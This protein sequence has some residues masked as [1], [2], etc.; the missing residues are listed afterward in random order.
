MLAGGWPLQEALTYAS[1]SQ[2][3]GGIREAERGTGGSTR[4]L[5]M[6]VGTAVVTS[7]HARGRARPGQTQGWEGRQG[8][9]LSLQ[10]GEAAKSRREAGRGGDTA[11]ISPAHVLT[12]APALTCPRPTFSLLCPPPNLLRTAVCAPLDPSSLLKGLT[13]IQPSGRQRPPAP[14]GAATAAHLQARPCSSRREQGTR[15]STPRLSPFHVQP[16][17]P[18]TARCQGRVRAGLVAG[19]TGLGLASFKSSVASAT[20]A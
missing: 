11:A 3:C 14:H 16:V 17:P 6:Q 2:G 9:G 4:S 8:G 7:P 20:A 19:S 15:P 13:L 10:K 18:G 1:C 12:Q 5:V